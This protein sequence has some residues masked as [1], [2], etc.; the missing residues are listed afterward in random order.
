MP[1]VPKLKRLTTSDLERLNPVS[2]ILKHKVTA[3]FDHPLVKQYVILNYRRQMRFIVLAVRLL[4]FL[5]FVVSLT[6]LAFSTKMPWELSNAA[7]PWLRHEVCG[8]RSDVN[9]QSDN[10]QSTYS[11][12]FNHNTSRCGAWLNSTF[13]LFGI[14]VVTTGIWDLF[15]Y[16][17]ICITGWRRLFRPTRLHQFTV[18]SR[19]KDH[20]VVT[21]YRM[22]GF[23]LLFTTAVFITTGNW[24]CGLVALLQ[25]WFQIPSYL[26]Q[27]PGGT[28]LLCVHRVWSTS[29]RMSHLL[30][31]Y[32]CG[33]VTVFVLI[34]GETS[35]F[36]NWVVAVI[37][38][39]AF[40]TGDVSMA[41]DYVTVKMF[42][43]HQM[44]RYRDKKI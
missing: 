8:N 5:A 43:R 38:N 37:S 26:L 20:H 40:I 12:S 2:S 11:S 33:V 27:L 23:I 22:N 31:V 13:V 6:G 21:Q 36:S 30:L 18:P 16:V 14:L 24:Y 10:T 42:S 29:I 4:L 41:R 15:H 32:I 39:V 17:Q 1:T 34:F 44:K 19:S 7:Q 25:A 9:V 28:A 35:R 3:L